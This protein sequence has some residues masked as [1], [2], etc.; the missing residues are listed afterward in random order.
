[1]RLQLPQERLYVRHAIDNMRTQ[2]QVLRIYL[3]ILPHRLR[4]R[5]ILDARIGGG[6]AKLLDHAVRRLDDMNLLAPQSHR[7]R[8][9]SRASAHIQ[10][11]AP[12]FHHRQQQVQYR[13]VLPPRIQPEKPRIRLPEIVI[14]PRS[15]GHHSLRLLMVRLYPIL[16]RLDSSHL[17]TSPINLKPK[18]TQYNTTSKTPP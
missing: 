4:N 5:H 3:C 9:P 7:Q 14:R 2:S 8:H 6:L 17:T 13:I 15:S 16:P 11:C 12:R 1:M 18:T 10:R